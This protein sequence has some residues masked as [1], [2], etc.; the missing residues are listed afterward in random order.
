M[1]YP[2]FTTLC[3]QAQTEINRRVNELQNAIAKLTD[4]NNM[5]DA[6][7]ACGMSFRLH[8]NDNMPD[9][10]EL[11]RDITGDKLLAYLQD[12]SI[13]KPSADKQKLIATFK[14]NPSFSHRMF[15]EGYE[16]EKIL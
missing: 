5:A 6:F 2:R 11:M 16:Y 4:S 8:G 13:I 3:A 12:D 9:A 15:M 10:S 1:P 14:K 7:F